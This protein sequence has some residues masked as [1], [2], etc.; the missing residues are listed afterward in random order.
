[1]FYY[2][3]ISPS[4]PQLVDR[5]GLL[6]RPWVKPTGLEACR[7][8]CS[9][10]TGDGSKEW[11]IYNYDNNSGVFSAPDDSGSIIVDGLGRIGGLLTGGARRR[12]LML[13]M[14]PP[15]FG[16]GLASRST[17]HLHISTPPASP[18]INNYDQDYVL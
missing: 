4:P 13:L 12:H 15:C 6:T 3:G 7:N 8:D 18:R 1:M 17:T 2:S 9:Q 5:T 11:G 16:Y 14:P 10:D